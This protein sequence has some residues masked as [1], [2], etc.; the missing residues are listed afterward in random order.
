[1]RRLGAKAVFNYRDPNIVK[2]IKDVTGD[3]IHIVLDAYSE[4]ESQ[5]ICIKAFGPGGGRL[6]LVQHEAPYIRRLRKDVTVE[7]T[8]LYSVFGRPYMMM[9]K[10][11][12]AD[13]DDRVQLVEYLRKTLPD[14]LRRG[15]LRPMKV[16]LWE[17]GLE[18]ISDGFQYM[19]QGRVSAEKLVF[20]LT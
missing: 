19:I 7:S 11:Y 6:M 10:T 13:P 18:N 16:H 3:S 4:E 15:L 1:M 5:L 20:R 14:H 17:G 2:K 8:M 9:G 12:E